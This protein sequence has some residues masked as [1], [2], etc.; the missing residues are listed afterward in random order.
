MNVSIGVNA[1][2]ILTTNDNNPSDTFAQ[3]LVIDALSGQAVVSHNGNTITLTGITAN[4]IELKLGGTQALMASLAPLDATLTSTNNTQKVATLNSVLDFDL[5][6]T[7]ARHFLDDNDPV[8]HTQSIKLDAASGTSAQAVAGND[9]IK[10]TSG[11][12]TVESTASNTVTVPVNSCL[13]PDDFSLDSS[14]N[15]Q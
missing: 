3:Q 6:M 2:D 8:T 12:I 5:I 15:C 11:S 14:A 7:N 10:V 4:G 13:D 1:L 9:L